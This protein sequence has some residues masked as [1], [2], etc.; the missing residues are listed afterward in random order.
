MFHS[1]FYYLLISAYLQAFNLII[2]DSPNTIDFFTAR[3]E[4]LFLYTVKT[5]VKFY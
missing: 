3:K 1:T 4:I 5:L 2:M